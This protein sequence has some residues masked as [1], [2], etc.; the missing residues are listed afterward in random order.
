MALPA[1]F[2]SF[3]PLLFAWANTVFHVDAGVVV[4]S[5]TV[6]LQPRLERAKMLTMIPRRSLMVLLAVA[7]PATAELKSIATDLRPEDSRSSVV[8]KS[9]PQGDLKINLYFPKD[10]KGSDRRPAIVLFFGGGFVSGTPAQFTS[11][12]EYFASRGLVAGS[13]EYRIG[14]THH[15]PPEKCAEDAKSA[16]RW[17]RAN[18]GR[19]GIDPKRVIAGGGSAGGTI[20]AFTAYNAVYE[21]DGEDTSISSVPDALVLYNPALGFPDQFSTTDEQKKGRDEQ[22][23]QKLGGFIA[24]WKVTK[25]GPPAI[26]FF[27][28]KDD[29]LLKARDFAAGLIAAGT[30][31]E[32]Y[33][34]ADQGHGFFNDRPNSPWHALVVRQTDLFLASLGYVK[35]VPTIAL[36]AG[37]GAVLQKTLP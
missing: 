23:R 8:Y 20:S 24:N 16:V 2:A 21:P 17:L 25:A 11:T 26:L 14:N 5:F 35:G 3:S 29:L 36:P 34:A 9:T 19:L 32:L 1:A 13:A 10:W 28:T 15:T 27:G 37:S 22:Q 18:A 33:T 7:I 4:V 12:A 30:R 6:R 31:A